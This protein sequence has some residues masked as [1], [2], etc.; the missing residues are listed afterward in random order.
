[1]PKQQLFSRFDDPVERLPVRSEDS[2]V[3]MARSRF[4][5]LV[6]FAFVPIALGSVSGCG[7]K[8]ADGTVVEAPEIDEAQKAEVAAENKQQRLERLSKFSRK[9]KNSRTKKAP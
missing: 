2:L 8:P 6:A 5:S 9:G 1:M 7:S 3:Q 4:L